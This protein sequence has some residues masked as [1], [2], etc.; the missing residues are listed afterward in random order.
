MY[1]FNCYL[2]PSPT[3]ITPPFFY[4]FQ[5]IKSLIDELSIW[6]WA[7]D[8]IH[9]YMDIDV[10]AGHMSMLPCHFSGGSSYG[11]QPLGRFNLST[12]LWFHS[13]STVVLA[14][15]ELSPCAV[16]FNLAVLQ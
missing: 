12:Y 8:Q 4:I 5:A 3:T 15:L 2:L 16:L 9:S 7:E 10:I 13:T 1:L 6:S 11:P 14:Y